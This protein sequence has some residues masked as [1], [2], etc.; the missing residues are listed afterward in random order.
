[1][2][3]SDDLA[4]DAEVDA[5]TG[6]GSAADGPIEPF[7]GVDIDADIGRDGR[8]PDDDTL[9]E[10]ET[11]DIERQVAEITATNRTRDTAEQVSIDPEDVS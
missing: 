5:T 10:D 6:S 11:A 9:T 4:R 3:E 2:A 1:M 7:D 8:A